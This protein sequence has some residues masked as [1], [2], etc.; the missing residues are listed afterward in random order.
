MA[1]EKS[2][3]ELDLNESEYYPLTGYTVVRVPG[4]WIYDRFFGTQG[5]FVPFSDEF[6]NVPKGL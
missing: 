6:Q 3:Y 4:G 5:V 1:E 2:I